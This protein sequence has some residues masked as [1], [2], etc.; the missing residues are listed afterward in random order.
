MCLKSILEEQT[1]NLPSWVLQDEQSEQK[2][3][4]AELAANYCS[5]MCYALFFWV[6]GQ[7]KTNQ[8]KIPEKLCVYAR[9]QKSK[10]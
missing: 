10:A 3:P 4:I 5:R 8:P 1:S 7:E 9:S 2:H 6:Q